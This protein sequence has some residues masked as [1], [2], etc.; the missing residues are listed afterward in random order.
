MATPT[1]ISTALEVA[2][3]R[4]EEVVS[5]AKVTDA[6]SLA[7]T[8]LTRKAFSE[9]L[10]RVEAYRRERESIAPETVEVWYDRARGLGWTLETWQAA[11]RKV[12]DQQYPIS[13]RDFFGEHPAPGMY[14]VT[15]E[16]YE[17]HIAAITAGIRKQFEER[18][19]IKEREIKE[20]YFGTTAGQ[21]E[22]ELNLKA[23]K[24]LKR[25][26]ALDQRSELLDK[27]EA[28][29]NEKMDEYLRKIGSIQ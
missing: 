21:R 27:R 15:Q 22:A 19:R 26:A 3:S 6:L 18:L 28:N 7:T 2:T 16:S 24:L 14:A 29:L 4:R 5:T 10:A 9:A 25:E 8:P 11:L 20:Q 12:M 1:Q 17:A 13:G 23:L